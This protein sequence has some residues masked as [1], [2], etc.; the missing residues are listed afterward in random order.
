MR[1]VLS[2]FPCSMSASVMSLRT[3][4]SSADILET[5]CHRVKQPDIKATMHVPCAF[6]TYHLLKKCLQ[7]HANAFVC[8]QF[9]PILYMTKESSVVWVSTNTTTK[10]GM[11]TIQYISRKTG[12]LPRKGHFLVSRLRCDSCWWIKRKP[13]PAKMEPTRNEGACIHM[14][15][16][17]LCIPTASKATRR[18]KSMPWMELNWSPKSLSYYARNTDTPS[19]LTSGCTVS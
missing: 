14:T 10:D 11:A 3:N 7:L 13:L 2:K 16:N 15:I 18:W 17:S 12:I 5:H 8:I 4:D 6:W 19:S 1:L 9:Q